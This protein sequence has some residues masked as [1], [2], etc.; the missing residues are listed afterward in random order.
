MKKLFWLSALF[1]FASFIGFAQS[2]KVFDN[3]TV[4]CMKGTA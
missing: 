3:L 2:G 4:S 1:V